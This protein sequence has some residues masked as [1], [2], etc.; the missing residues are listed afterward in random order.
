MFFI[1]TPKTKI[2]LFFHISLLGSDQKYEME[3]QA[4]GQNLILR[5]NWSGLR[6]PEVWSGCLAR[7]AA[8]APHSTTTNQIAMTGGAEVK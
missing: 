3:K 7:E 2:C 4:P 8:Q 1:I 5:F 6:D